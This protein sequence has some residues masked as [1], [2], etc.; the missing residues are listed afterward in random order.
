[1]DWKAKHRIIEIEEVQNEAD[2]TVERMHVSHNPPMNQHASATVKPFLNKSIAGGEML[3]D[4]VVIDII[5][6][7]DVML[8]WRKQTLVKREP[9]C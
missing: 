9:D 5:Y 3:K 1:M 7:N 2:R 4:V 6:L 8:V